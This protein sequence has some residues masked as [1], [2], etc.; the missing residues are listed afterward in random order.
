[1]R[2]FL[3]LAAASA[4]G[5]LGALIL[6][7]YSFSGLTVIGAGAALGLFAAETARAAARGGGAR[8]AVGCAAVAAA[9]MVGAAWIATGHDLSFLDPEGWVAVV[10]AAVVAGVRAWWSRPAPGTP[11]PEP[12]PPG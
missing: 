7:E 1:V 3:G 9:S 12:A 5:V 10:I 2:L 4:V 8:L 6:G 11:P